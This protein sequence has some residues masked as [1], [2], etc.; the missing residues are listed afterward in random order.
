MRFT[1]CEVNIVFQD[2]VRIAQRRR[3]AF[4][5]RAARCQ[6]TLCIRKL[7]STLHN[8][9]KKGKFTQHVVISNLQ[10]INI[11][12]AWLTEIFFIIFFSQNRGTE[13]AASCCPSQHH[14][15]KIV[16]QYIQIKRTP[17]FA[18][19]SESLGSYKLTEKQQKSHEASLFFL[20]RIRGF[21]NEND[22]VV[23]RMLRKALIYLCCLICELLMNRSYFHPQSEFEAQNDVATRLPPRCENSGAMRA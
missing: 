16:Y 22:E 17:T 20:R 18:R 15:S 23:G 11:S 12:I 21:S 2:E 1:D 3:R 7:P 4:E 13:L 10:N 14:G 19:Q 5:C 9:H 6:S 8:Y